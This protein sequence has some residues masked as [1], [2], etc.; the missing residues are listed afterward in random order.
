[1]KLERILPLGALLV[2]PLAAGRLLPLTP[3]APIADDRDVA[4]LMP[5][6]VLVY[7]EAPGLPDLLDEG[8]DHPLVA[9]LLSSELGAALM[10]ETGATPEGHLAMAEAI[11]GHPVLPALASL[12]ANGAA[13][14]TGLGPAG[15][16]WV[17]VLHGDDEFLLEELLDKLFAVIGESVGLPDAFSEPH[18]RVRGAD[19]WYLGDE[20]KLAQR[21][22][23]FVASNDEGLLRD[24]LDLAADPEARGLLGQAGF[25]EARATREGAPL[26]WGWLDVAG[27]ESLAKKLGA[28]EKIDNLRA[29]NRQPAAQMLL[30]PGL[31]ALGTADTLTFWLDVGDD[32]LSLGTAGSGL[33]P[34]EVL[35]PQAGEPLPPLPAPNAA[36]CGGAVFYRDF[37][38]TFAHRVDLFPPETM[39]G[40]SEAITGLALVFGGQ[41][42]SKDV[43]PEISAWYRMVSRRPRFEEGVVPEIELPAVALLIGVE[44]P[45]RMGS[46]LVSAFQTALGL[47]NIGMSQN[48]QQPLRMELALEGDVQVTIARHPAPGPEDG[49]DL[50]YNLAPAFALVN[51][52]FIVGT[53]HSLVRDLVRELKDSPGGPAS[54]PV[55][56][57]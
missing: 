46:E 40:F 41:D 15:A 38:A 42:V 25:A 6:R 14:G 57:S 37:D 36:D 44:D 24:V 39:P 22:S 32:N 12:T 51:D 18:N 10:K 13:L 56:E 21:E 1:M 19:L 50:Q 16:V 54:G 55:H 4:T 29:M 31:S 8:L 23:L 45:E 17:L 30:G 34:S 49:V 27:L 48:G 2:L 43:L 5:E 20:L 11:V 52:T 33:A 7:A 26:V 47:V 28:S 3:P 35:M 53:H 9:R